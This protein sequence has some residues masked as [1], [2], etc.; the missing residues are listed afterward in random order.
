VWEN[1]WRSYCLPDGSLPRSLGK[2]VA[3]SPRQWEWFYNAAEDVLAQSVGDAVWRY[4]SCAPDN[5]DF[6]RLTRGD[7]RYARTGVESG[8]IS[9]EFVP[10]S[11]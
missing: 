1:F 5:S 10:V 3:S 2:W 6:V 8:G 9:A 7:M 4:C 11:V